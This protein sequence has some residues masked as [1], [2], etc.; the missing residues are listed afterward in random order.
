MALS[1]L[2]KFLSKNK[3][4]IDKHVIEFA[5]IQSDKLSILHELFTTNFK[6]ES[7]D[8]WKDLC[9]T[10][11]LKRSAETIEDYKDVFIKYKLN[12]YSGNGYPECDMEYMIK[13]I[14]NLTTE[15]EIKTMIQ[16][17]ISGKIGLMDSLKLLMYGN[18]DKYEHLINELYPLQIRTY[19]MNTNYQKLHSRFNNLMGANNKIRNVFMD[20]VYRYCIEK[21]VDI[22]RHPNSN[23]IYRKLGYMY[24][25]SDKFIHNNEFAKSNL[26]ELAILIVSGI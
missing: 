14:M 12:Q 9:E 18:V 17:I 21:G 4:V 23:F 20:K 3:P 10:L 6:I 19:I 15:S 8:S 26:E 24:K 13:N 2:R 11:K 1:K 5:K 16:D 22:I 7:E 25:K